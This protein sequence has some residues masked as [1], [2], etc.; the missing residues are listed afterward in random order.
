MYEE[1]FHSGP[2]SDE[3]I[4]P[5]PLELNVAE[6]AP[7]CTTDSPA[8]SKAG[9]NI[10]AKSSAQHSTLSALSCPVLYSQDNR[11]RQEALRQSQR[12][13]VLC[14]TTCTWRV[15]FSCYWYA[16]LPLSAAVWKA[17]CTLGEIS[18]IAWLVCQRSVS[19]KLAACPWPDLSDISLRPSSSE[20]LLCRAASES[21]TARLLGTWPFKAPVDK[22]QIQS[23]FVAY[24]Q[25]C[26]IRLTLSHWPA[27]HS[28]LNLDWLPPATM[29]HPDTIS[30]K[31]RAYPLFCGWSHH[32]AAQFVS[33]RESNL[34]APKCP[35][36][37]LGPF[38]VWLLL[39]WLVWIPSHC[40]NLS[41]ER[42]QIPSARM[43]AVLALGMQV[44]NLC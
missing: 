23:A 19:S 12:Q 14:Y 26:P 24:Q 5:R 22:A 21:A 9:A 16:G 15:E 17:E 18:G 40:P 42:P 2:T 8:T 1:F 37:F 27:L 25:Q 13:E 6:F 33:N 4:R 39:F 36:H 44:H 7:P 34:M 29:Q 38:R 11:G 30:L 28:T 3:K 31:K 20:I 41:L 43:H 35:L 32:S 10:S